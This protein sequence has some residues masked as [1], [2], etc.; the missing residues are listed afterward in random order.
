MSF[1][2]HCRIEGK[3]RRFGELKRKYPERGCLSERTSIDE[4]CLSEIC[5]GDLMK[6]LLGTQYC[7]GISKEFRCPKQI[8]TANGMNACTKNYVNG[9]SY[10]EYIIKHE[11]T[12]EVERKKIYF[13]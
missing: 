8:E 13:N 1:S 4:K 2:E 3:I 7:F 11:K 9:V 6:E 10:F 12:G 5:G